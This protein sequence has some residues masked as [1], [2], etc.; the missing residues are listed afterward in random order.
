MEK[1]VEL[2]KDLLAV[3]F[4]ELMNKYPFDKIT[5]KMITDGAGVI[6]PTFYN[7]YQDKIELL[8]ECVENS[9]FVPLRDLVEINMGKEAFKMLILKMEGNIK[10]YRNAFKISQSQYFKDMFVENIRQ[11]IMSYFEKNHT[12]IQNINVE[13]VSKFYALSITSVLYYWL[14]DG[15]DNIS[16]EELFKAYD[17]FISNTIFDVIEKY[18]E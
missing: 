1:K 8:Q 15:G 10:F 12:N 6:R 9:L 13:T 2:T 18:Q 14:V 11:L 4:T 16:G 7:Y 3:S 17:F 5:I